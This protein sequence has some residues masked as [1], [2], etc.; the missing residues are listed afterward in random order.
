MLNYLKFNFLNNTF[1]KKYIIK[2]YYLTSCKILTISGI[3]YVIIDVLFVIYTLRNI[4]AQYYLRL[5][6]FSCHCFMY[7]KP[8]ACAHNRISMCVC[9]SVNLRTR[10]WVLRCMSVSMIEAHTSTCLKEYPR[11]AHA[12]EDDIVHEYVRKR[13][14]GT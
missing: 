9:V 5:I 8:S 4:V 10:T 1:R 11:G 3:L 7:S 6:G 2:M 12:H 13:V 14:R